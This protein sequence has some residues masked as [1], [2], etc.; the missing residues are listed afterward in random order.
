MRTVLVTG[1]TT[2]LGK[3]IADR[4]R[5]LGWRVFTSSHRAASGADVVADLSDPT[6][7]DRL[8]AA[9]CALNGG[10][11]PDALV[12]N[13]ALFTGTDETLHRINFESPHR[14]TELMAEREKGVGCV[15]NI[16]DCRVLNG[17]MV[18]DESAYCAAKRSLLEETRTNAARHWT[19][20]RVNGVAPGPVM[21]PVGVREKA[22]L[23][24]FGRPTPEQIAEA[25]AFL[26]SAES[27]SGCVIPVDGGQ[28]LLAPRI[29]P[30]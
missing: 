8:F 30:D 29:S 10:N 23:T 21:T 2:R 15:V 16:L 26:L 9:V 28:S 4:L 7:A 25:V 17:R 5:A 19:T 20:L 14:L 18:G 13:A 22:G 11:P 3:V 24:P 12:N 27:T 6:G 1:G